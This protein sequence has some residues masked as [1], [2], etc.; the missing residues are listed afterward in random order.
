LPASFGQG[1][2]G[3]QPRLADAVEWIEQNNA[4]VLRQQTELCEIPAPPFQE[5]KRAAEFRKRLEA[6]GLKARID[7]EGNVIA[8]YSG[9]QASPLV[10]LS[11]HLDTVFPAG[12]NVKVT[13]LN[14]RLSGAGISD[15][16]RGL[17]VILT[18][19][20]TLKQHRLV[21]K[22]TIWLVGTVGEEGE[23]DLRGVG[24]FSERVRSRRRC[25]R[26]TISYPS[27]ARGNP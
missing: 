23:G 8:E 20:R 21:P 7:L 4:W 1:V 16:C 12:T 25:R 17:A 19:A 13:S 3:R 22:G 5:Q 2:A 18:V 15:D 11:A 10:V 24:I 26:R 27:M 6:I 14:G 9:S